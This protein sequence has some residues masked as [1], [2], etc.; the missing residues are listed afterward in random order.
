MSKAILEREVGR[1]VTALAYPYGGAGACTEETQ[2]LAREAGYQLAF[3]AQKGINRPGRS[4]PFALARVSVGYADSPT[5]VRTRNILY[6]AFGSSL[7]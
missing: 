1:P 3:T 6:A 5:L 2:S 7:V 4:R